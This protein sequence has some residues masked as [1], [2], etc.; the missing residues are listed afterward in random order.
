MRNIKLWL[1]SALIAALVL[2]GAGVAQ[3]P[4]GQP[5]QAKK[6]PVRVFPEPGRLSADDIVERILSFDKN[7]DGKVTKDELPE[8]MHH[9]ITLGDTNK[10]GALD[11]EEIKKLVTAGGFGPR[12]EFDAFIQKKGIGPGRPGPGPLCDGPGPLG[13]DLGRVEEVVD[14][15]KLSG[16]K[17][18]QAKATVKA[19]QENVRKLMD[20]ARAELLQ[21]MKAVLSEEEFRDFQA[22]LDR[23][24]GPCVIFNFGPPDAPGPGV[25]EK[26][27]DQRPK[28]RR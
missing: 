12:G 16:K 15:L 5:P 19:Y 21:K 17:Q 24:A 7:K 26:K 8:R 1:T 2:G 10:D 11:R 14:D 9:L 20:Q 13:A 3:P 22:A 23:P 6:G 18:D 27:L 25:V 4:Q 28:E